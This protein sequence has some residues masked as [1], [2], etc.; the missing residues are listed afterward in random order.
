[1]MANTR[2]R[3][4]NHRH[5]LGEIPYIHQG[6]GELAFERPNILAPG[7]VD[8]PVNNIQMPVSYLSPQISPDEQI[9][10]LRGRRKI[11]WS[12]Q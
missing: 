1:M 5:T 10:Q 4:Q 11:S 2:R 6:S 8:S 12:P 7:L 3:A 9:I